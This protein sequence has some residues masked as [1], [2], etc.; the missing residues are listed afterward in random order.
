MEFLQATINANREIYNL[1]QSLPH[2]LLC[3]KL[4]KGF[5][6]DISIKADLEAEN[7]F[8]KHLEKFGTIYSEENGIIG[9]GDDI[10][11]IDPIDGS[12]N[13]VSNIPYY[14]TSVAKQK[15]GVTTHAVVANLSNGSLYIKKFD[16]F[17]KC[18]LFD[19]KK[20]NIISNTISNLGIFERSYSSD[21]LHNFLKNNHLKYRSMGAL[22]LSLSTAH[23][24]NFVLYEGQTREFDIAGGWYMCE[25]LLRFK[26]NNYLLVSKDKGI[27][28]KICDFI[29]EQYIDGFF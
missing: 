15:N 9:Q 29:K 14:G 21:K 19:S 8:I 26:N 6:G 13:F 3:K 10:I 17:K 27:F 4:F 24:V 12:E 11:I 5:G 2:T 25:D 1:L 18:S 23:E 7:I 16:I 28:D 22:A 20:E